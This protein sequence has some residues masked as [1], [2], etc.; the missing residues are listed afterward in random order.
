[1]FQY[2]PYFP[3][4][5]IYDFPWPCAAAPPLAGYCR[6]SQGSSLVMCAAYGLVKSWDLSNSWIWDSRRLKSYFWESVFVR[7]L[8]IGFGPFLRLV[9]REHV[10]R[11]TFWTRWPP[12]TRALERS[13]LKLQISYT[14]KLYSQL[15]LYASIYASMFLDFSWSKVESSV[16]E[17][18]LRRQIQ[19]LTQTD[20]VV[21]GRDLKE[22]AGPAFGKP[23]T[24]GRAPQGSHEV[25]YL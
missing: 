5:C 23:S 4:L 2:F 15:S 19:R 17:E 21:V 1:M 7:G 25:T 13:E 22:L 8:C 18:F 6:F 16:R 3:F 11:Y 14:D 10:S 12:G 24:I 9:Q 20:I